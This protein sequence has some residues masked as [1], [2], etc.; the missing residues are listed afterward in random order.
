[1][2]DAVPQ[3][4]MS[5]NWLVLKTIA[6]GVGLLVAYGV[7]FVCGGLS[8]EIRTQRRGWIEQRDAVVPVLASDPAFRDVRVVTYD[9]GGWILLEGKVP[10][11]HDK[12]RLMEAVSQAIGRRRAEN[13]VDGVQVKTPLP[14]R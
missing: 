14:P 1:M 13:A 12:F 6:V 4:D 8:G 9:D 11:E 10:T 2:R 7:G 3:R 5:R